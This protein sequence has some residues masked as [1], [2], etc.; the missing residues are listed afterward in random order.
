MSIRTSFFNN[1]EYDAMS[2]NRRF[3]QMF[4]DGVIA[5]ESA[6]DTALKVSLQS[7]LTLKIS[8][9]IYHIQGA[10]LE[11]YGNGETI[12]LPV[13]STQAR[14][15]AVCVEYNLNAGVNNA[16]LVTVSGTPAASPEYPTLTRTDLLW[17]RP[18]AYVLVPANASSA[19]SIIDA[20]DQSKVKTLTYGY[21]T[22]LPET[23]NEGDIFFLI[24]SE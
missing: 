3:S 22:S 10:I 15:D 5:G 20:R 11:V 18:L 6:I 17:Q 7:G 4:S 2:V 13:A 21:G 14:Y 16:R 12:T 1:I 24:T 9:G 8:N 19:G 23:G